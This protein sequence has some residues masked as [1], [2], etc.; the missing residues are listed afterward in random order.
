VD[1]LLLELPAWVDGFLQDFSYLGPFVILLLCGIGLPLPEEVTLIASGLL[2]HQGKVEFLPI[3]VVCSVAILLGD[4]L[5]Y[6]LGRRMGK[7]ALEWRL[8]AKVLHPERFAIVEEK[9]QRY[10]SWG[11]FFCRF[12][13][14]IRIPGYFSAG[15]LRMSYVRFLILDGLGV[16]ISVPT[17]IWI[18]RAFGGQVEKMEEQ[19]ENFH[20]ILAFSL[21]A[22][23]SILGFRILI[24][25]RE[26]EARA[27][28]GEPEE[29]RSDS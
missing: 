22:I 9:F 24:R 18:A 5:P 27:L 6:W 17:S 7:R 20:L 1:L 2:L 3:T 25:R 12:L 28:A 8:V 4:S 29:S 10:G 26:R 16:L 19:M 13:P 14:G 23:L 11:I 21:V 15:T